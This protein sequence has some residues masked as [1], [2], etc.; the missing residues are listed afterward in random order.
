MKVNFWKDKTVLLTGHTGFKGSWLSILLHHFGANVIGVSLEPNKDSSLFSQAEVNKLCN[1]NICD[2][3][4]LGK[5]QEIVCNTKIDI[6]FHLAAQSLVRKSYMEP[7][8]TFDVNVNGTANILELI[9]GLEHIRVGIFATTDKVYQNLESGISFR[10]T[11]RLGG[12]DPYSSSKAASELVIDSY[13][14]SFFTSRDIAISSVRAGNVIGGGDWSRDRILPDAVRAWDANKSVKIRSPNSIRPWQHV[15][16]CL[17]GYMLLAEKLWDDRLLQ[18]PYNFGPTK[19]D[20]LNVLEIIQHAAKIYET[21]KVTVETGNFPHEAGFLSLDVTKA[22]QILNYIPKWNALEAIHRSARWYKDF[23]Q[24]FDALG[25]CKK[26]IQEY[27][28]S[29]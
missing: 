23:S 17:Y 28:A 22:H 7:I 8:E 26:D 20:N 12:H 25:L 1:H 3:R 15:L 9:A 13:C 6:V 24:G 11:D 29:K 2:I 27:Q 16:D 21:D 5:L 14:K 18:G 10:E 19:G 4:D